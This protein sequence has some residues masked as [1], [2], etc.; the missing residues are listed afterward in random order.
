M[1]YNNIYN[2]TP[3]IITF[4]GLAKTFDTVDHRILLSKLYRYGIR[5]GPLE[6]LRDYLSDRPHRVKQRI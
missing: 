3:T 4:L 1:I 5:G 6:L 2:K